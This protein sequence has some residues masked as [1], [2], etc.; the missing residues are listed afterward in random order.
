MRFF[1]HFVFTFIIVSKNAKSEKNLALAK[2][3]K[4]GLK[5]IIKAI[6]IQL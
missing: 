6:K 3:R 2:C 5:K 1:D 4:C